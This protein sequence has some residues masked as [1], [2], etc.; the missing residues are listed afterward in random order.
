M[1]KEEGLKEI[2]NILEEA[3]RAGKLSDEEKKAAKE[4]KEML[5]PPRRKAYS[6]GSDG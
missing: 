2:G 1:S 5:T 6:G 4:L 3:D